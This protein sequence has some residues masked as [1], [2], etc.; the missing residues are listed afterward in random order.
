MTRIGVNEP[1][2]EQL[3]GIFKL[4]GSLSYRNPQ[5][6]NQWAGKGY[7]AA[8]LPMDA[9]FRRQGRRERRAEEVPTA[10][11]VGHS[12]LQEALA[13]GYTPPVLPTSEKSR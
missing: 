9:A 11:R 5:S 1:V 13:N 7:P 3:R 10:R 8:S 4:M 6:L 12:L 2:S